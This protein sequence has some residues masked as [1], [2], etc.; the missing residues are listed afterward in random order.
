[1]GVFALVFAAAVLVHGHG[2]LWAYDRAFAVLALALALLC[3]SVRRPFLAPYARVDRLRAARVTRVWSL[4]LGLIAASFAL[5]AALDTR[6]ATTVF[7]WLVPIGVFVIASM[8]R[9]PEPVEDESESLLL[10]A[11][12]SLTSSGPRSRRQRAADRPHSVPSLVEP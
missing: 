5:G 4:V 12:D 2:R 8:R 9:A 6:A 3:S 7:N 11:L 10:G 1:V